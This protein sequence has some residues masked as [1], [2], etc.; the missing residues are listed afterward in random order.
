MEVM[1]AIRQR[2][3]VHRYDPA[4]AVDDNTVMR[5]L[6]AAHRAPCHRKTWPWRFHRVG[7][8]G[9]ALIADAYVVYKAQRVEGGL[10]DAARRRAHE[11]MLEAP[12]LILVTQVLG[13]TAHRRKEDY[14]ACAAALQNF[15]LSLAADGVG[16]KW[17]SSGVMTSPVVY[18]LLGVDSD[19]QEVIAMMLV[20]HAREE[21]EQ[22]ERPPVAGFIA[23]V[24]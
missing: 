19:E 17:S 2:R 3:T 1:D 8:K 18:E 15:Q 6:D 23:S 20:G 21:G 11:K 24:P 14:A 16:S 12:E 13:D 9:R 22:P 4:R 7:P 5:A 10:G